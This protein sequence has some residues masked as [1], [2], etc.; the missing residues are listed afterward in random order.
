MAS[1]L[2][3]EDEEEEEAGSG[4]TSCS[5]PP[6]PVLAKH[7][8]SS[9]GMLHALFP[10]SRSNS[11]SG[12]IGET[13]EDGARPSAGVPR[14]TSASTSTSTPTGTSAA[15]AY[16]EDTS[17]S[18]SISSKQIDSKG[19]VGNWDGKA[20]GWE[21]VYHSDGAKWHTEQAGDHDGPLQMKKNPSMAESMGSIHSSESGS[22]ASNA[23]N[24]SRA[25]DDLALKAEWADISGDSPEMA[26]ETFRVRR[27]N[28]VPCSG[29]KPDLA[30]HWAEEDKHLR[31]SQVSRDLSQFAMRRDGKLL[32]AMIGLPARGKSYIAQGIAK[33]LNWLG[34]KTRIFNAGNYRREVCGPEAPASFFDPDNEEGKMLRERCALLALGD[35]IK[36]LKSD[37]GYVAIFD[38]T[39][40]TKKRRTWLRKLVAQSQ[41]LGHRSLKRMSLGAVDEKIQLT[42]IESVCEDD[43]L[44]WKNVKNAKLNSPDYAG[45]E[46]DAVMRDFFQRIEQ[47]KRIYQMVEE[48]EGSPFIRLENTGERLVVF[49]SHGYISGDIVQ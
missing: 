18:S 32:L 4:S 39:N 33:H 34:I 45:W 37:E 21:K 13:G 28:S 31:N 30:L 10:P 36:Y 1:L 27:A 47:Y 35:A 9:S 20:G 16:P 42:F 49:R 26:R 48:E 19:L 14:S 38:A 2:R 46:P 11:S 24:I 22:D 3:E 6:L 44:I 7:R 12:S 15:A 23:F 41:G 5:S 8:S 25:A 40:T 29:W 17:R 43:E